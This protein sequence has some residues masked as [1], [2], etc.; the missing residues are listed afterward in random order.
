MNKKIFLATVL[1]LSLAAEVE[2]ASVVKYPEGIKFWI[3]NG[4]SWVFTNPEKSSFLEVK[5]ERFTGG[6]GARFFIRFLQ[7]KKTGKYISLCLK[8]NNQMK[9]IG[10]E[11]CQ[12][13]P[14]LQWVKVNDYWLL[15]SEGWTGKNKLHAC[16]TPTRFS[17]A[18]P[19]ELLARK[20][21]VTAPLKVVTAPFKVE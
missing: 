12:T 2:A 21:E 9:T 20:W 10:T 18:C 3:W 1:A 14:K 15:T 5:T 13:M 6:G 8:G 16:L 4:A 19:A 11:K 17:W 7:S